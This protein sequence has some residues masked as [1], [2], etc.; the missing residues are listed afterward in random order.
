MHYYDLMM[1]QTR[2]GEILP[3]SLETLILTNRSHGPDH[4]GD[5][6]VVGKLTELAQQSRL[7]VPNLKKIRLSYI[8][9]DMYG[10]DP[11]YL[12]NG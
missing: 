3:R 12:T 1:S 7:C 4:F 10:S 2:L 6:D 9:T 8:L 11:G 5:I